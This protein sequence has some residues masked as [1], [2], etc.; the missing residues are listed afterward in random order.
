MMC[1]LC[2]CGS[3]KKY[4]DCCEQKPNP[5]ENERTQRKLV[6]EL[7]KMRSNYK[8]VC[9]YP[10]CSHKGIH[11]HTISQKAILSLIAENNHVLMPIV[12]V[13]QPVD[14]IPQGI[15][16]Q[17]STFFCF[18]SNH[19]KIFSCIDVVSPTLSDHIKFMYAYRA[20]A[21]TY[22]KVQRELFCLENQFS[23]YNMTQNIRCVL[24]LHE[25]RYNMLALEGCKSLFDN[26]IISENY[27]IISSK[28]VTLDHK[29]YFSAATC[30]C[31]AFD[32]YGSEVAFDNNQLSMLYVSVIPGTNKTDLIFS[33]LKNDN[34]IYKKFAKQLSIVPTPFII[35]YLNNLLPLYCENITIGPKLW[36]KWDSVA[37]NDFRTI[38][39]CGLTRET[40]ISSSQLSE[41]H[42]YNLFLKIDDE[43]KGIINTK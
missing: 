9:L 11:A 37:Q 38:I 14:L 31:P 17:A 40:K 1:D 7:V 29:V 33:W 41:T 3:G 16:T 6:A 19:D 26:A 13:C 18:C 34:T 5:F 28:V 2:L 4:A 32:L 39:D 36:N 35:K 30:F 20:F 8:K 21:S 10:N 25:L 42:K 22:Y 15:D 27:N 43:K 23:K 24:M 12:K